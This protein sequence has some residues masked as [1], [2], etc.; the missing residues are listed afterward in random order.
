MASEDAERH[1]TTAEV[2]TRLGV[3]PE[4]VYAYV[5]RGLLTSIRAGGRRGSLFSEADVD[6]LA[7]RGR[8]HRPAAGVVERIATD[9]T[10]IEDDELY[11]R[12]V[13]ATELAASRS[14][15]D[16]ARLLWT[17]RSADVAAPSALFSA[18]DRLVRM[19]RSATA[20]LP[21][22]ARLTDHLR[23][24]VAVLGAADPMRFDLSS[25][26]VVRTAETTL[27]TM[28]SVLPRHPSD[29][30]AARADLRRQGARSGIAETLWP[31]ELR[32]E[33]VID[34]ELVPQTLEPTQEVLSRA[35]QL[36]AQS[37]AGVITAPR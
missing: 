25:T 28:V 33:R 37:R 35:D 9:V 34:I 5:S 29:D 19:A 2:A 30:G 11:Y 4:T 18:P 23:V 22:A 17:G 12:G 6:R 20:Q 3:K 13:K 36:R 32:D 7:Q 16:V 8:E 31:G 15:E 1:L 26:A 14:L 27:A 24:A 10:L 21:S